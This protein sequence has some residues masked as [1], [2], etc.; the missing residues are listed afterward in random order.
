MRAWS[1]SAVSR[2]LIEDLLARRDG[3][4]RFLGLHPGCRRTRFFDQLLALGVRL[5]QHGQAFGLDPRELRL[6]LLGIGESARD[7]LAARLEHPQNRLVG[8]CVEHAA[9]DHE[10]D[11]LRA[12]MRPVDAEG[13][14]DRFD[15]SRALCG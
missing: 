8:E 1:R 2:A 6:D 5:F 9:H 12:E 10:A 13:A 3:F 4:L 15:L 11:D 14:G 7:L